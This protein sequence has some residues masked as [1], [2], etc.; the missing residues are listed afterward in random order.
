MG[1]FISMPERKI[2]SAENATS[3]YAPF[4]FAQKSLGW[5]YSGL[6]G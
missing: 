5:S 3:R 1:L 2:H 6:L 4:G